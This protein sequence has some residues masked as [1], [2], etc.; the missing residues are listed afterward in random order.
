[1]ERVTSADE[2]EESLVHAGTAPG[3]GTDAVVQGSWL[4]YFCLIQDPVP[5]SSILMDFL[6]HKN[7]IS[8][9]WGV[10]ARWKSTPPLWNPSKSNSGNCSVAFMSA[11]SWS[12]AQIISVLLLLCVLLQ[13]FYDRIFQYFNRLWLWNIMFAVLY[14]KIEFIYLFKQKSWFI[15]FY[16][17]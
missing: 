9:L 8:D 13:G 16:Y 17:S 7:N 2:E 10:T 11:V 4:W 1:M 14:I 12:L 6:W 3:V 5:C 15:L